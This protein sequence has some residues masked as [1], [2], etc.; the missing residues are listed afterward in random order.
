M[1][2]TFDA[3]SSFSGDRLSFPSVFVSHG[4]PTLII[5]N[6]PAREFLAGYGKTLGKPRAIVVISAQDTA[7][8]SVIDTAAR[9]HAVHD[10]HG[11]PQELYRLD[12]TPPGDPALASEVAALLR[13]AG[14]AVDESAN[15]GLDHGAWVPL[16]LMYPDAD[17]PVVSLALDL[18]LSN[19]QLIDVGRALAPLRMNGVLILAS[20]SFT[21]NL[22]DIRFGSPD[23]HAPYVTE[24]TD[25]ITKVLRDRDDAALA[26]W[27]T[28]AP[29]A[30][31][32][33]PTTEHFLPLLVA[34]GAGERTTV[35]H[36]SVTHGVLAMHAFAFA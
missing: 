20:G 9:H 24:F 29:H 4:A 12:Y 21:H 32:A 7:A 3:A 26:E 27:D 8:V 31:R 28:R 13:G 36:D 22:R 34:Y 2:V 5:E 10:F 16:K 33:H 18:S 1:A 23:I 6:A 14:V 35:L 15:G 17:I 11:F 30:R 25:W 19:A